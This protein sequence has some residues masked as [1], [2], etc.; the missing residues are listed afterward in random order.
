M[1]QET[2]QQILQ[3]IK[4]YQRIFIFRHI[5][6]DGD[7]VGASMGLR[8]ILRASFP[9]KEVYVIDSERSEYLAFLGEPDPEMDATAYLSEE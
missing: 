6:N 3:T 5:R 2:M 8:G 1:Y 4:A 7:C 9:E